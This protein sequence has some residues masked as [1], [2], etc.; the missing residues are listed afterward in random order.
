MAALEAITPAWLAPFTDPW[1]VPAPGPWWDLEKVEGPHAVEAHV[2]VGDTAAYVQTWAWSISPSVLPGAVGLEGWREVSTDGLNNVWHN[3][4]GG[5]WYVY[6]NVSLCKSW[7][8][9]EFG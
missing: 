2:E 9:L 6:S 4:G 3:P 1:E 7:D 5:C 8:P